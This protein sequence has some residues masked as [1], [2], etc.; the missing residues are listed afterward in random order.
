MVYLLNSEKMSGVF[1][2]IDTDDRL[3]SA[4]KEHALADGLWPKYNVYGGVPTSIS[5]EP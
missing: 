5:L 2:A 3:L 1:Y 4:C